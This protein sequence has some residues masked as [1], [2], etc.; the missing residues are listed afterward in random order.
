MTPVIVGVLGFAIGLAAHD[1]AIQALA[2]D[3]PLRPFVGA[4][5]QC[6]Q[7]RG[8]HRVSCPHC[9]RRVQREPIVALVS[10]VVALGFLHTL[11][12]TWL[13][14]PYLGFIL[15]TMALLV[16]DLE[17]FR[18]VDRLN[19]R[20]TLILTLG[21]AAAAIG[22]SALEDLWR[23]LAGAGV[24]F[25]GATLLW[26]I[27][28][29]N[30]FGAGDVKLAFQLGLFTAYLGWGWLGWAV[31]STAMIGGVIAIAMLA[32]GAAKMKTELPYG[33]PMILGAWLVIILAGA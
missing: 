20:G 26:L 15:L 6:R 1:L 7:N 2:D 30:G 21:L 13:L 31:F 16:T 14:L 22:V 10:T 8:W 33:P 18:I 27:V 5:P 28:R 17:E 12:L 3:Q 24:Y 32:L 29:G 4:C 25:A 9:G 19:L 23:A 11:G